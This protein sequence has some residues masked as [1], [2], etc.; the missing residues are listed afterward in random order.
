MAQTRIPLS[1][2]DE[3]ARILRER[4]EMSTAE[5]GL[6]VRTTN[7]LEERGIFTVRER[8]DDANT[9]T[10]DLAVAIVKSTSPTP[11]PDPVIY[12]MESPKDVT[13]KGASMRLGA[14]RCDL[15][16]GSISRNAYG[17]PQVSERHR[18]RYEFND[19]YRSALEGKGL[20]VAGTNPESGLVEIVEI[21]DHPFMVGV[22]FHPEK[23][24][25]CG[26]SILRNFIGMV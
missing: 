8:R 12:L 2:A 13:R 16:D 15:V 3:R 21:A 11:A 25:E 24:G 6:T 4:L 18:H 14:Y 26:L 20:R 1:K 23:S 7:C 9:R 22:Q 17:K 10:I 5:I 19:K